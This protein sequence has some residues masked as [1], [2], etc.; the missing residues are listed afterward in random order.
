MGKRLSASGGRGLLIALGTALV[1][2]AALAL[3]T[4]Q[5]GSADHFVLVHVAHAVVYV[6]AVFFVLSQSWR[7][8]SP[9]PGG[10][11]AGMGVKEASDRE[12]QDGETAPAQ[13][14]VDPSGTSSSARHPQLLPSRGRGVRAVLSSTVVITL[15]VAVL[16]RLIAL[17]APPTLTTDAYRYVWDGR[18]Q[19]AGIN[20][21]LHVPAAP[22]LAQLRDQI[23][24]PNIN[25]ADTHPTI[26]PPVAEMLFLVGTR[27]VDGIR[28]MQVLFMAMDLM[29]IW[30]LMRWLTACGLPRE[31]VL[32]YAWHPL[33]LWEFAGMAHIDGAGVM[34][35]VL[36]LL[37]GQTGRQG[38]A[39]AA[40]AAAGLAKYHFVLLVPAVWRRWGWR[41]PLAM[42][43]VALACY[44]PYLSAGS[45]VLGSLFVHLGE[46]GYRDGYGFYLVGLPKHFGLPHLPSLVFAGLAALIL[47][48]LA[49]V[50]IQR[51]RPRTVEPEHLIWLT[52]T[53]L[54]LISPHYPWYYTLAVPLLARR[55]SWPLLWMT[56]VVSGVYLER[57]DGWL[58]P[59]TR[60]KVFTLMFGGAA[61]LAVVGWIAGARRKTAQPIVH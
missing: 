57:P 24:F 43:A 37:A 1:G 39:G 45:K 13:T 4:L 28:G 61:L 40:F 50:I 44:L 33:P 7:S 55:M 51:T 10:E 34:F 6:A 9:P 21:Y 56:L 27:V 58:E 29:T 31:R 41:L 36:G 5:R 19:A 15:A 20:P 46:E 3:W 30:A 18:V 11:G 25:R 8:T 53:F 23:I 52:I 54:V 2:L 16:M 49:V 14:I 59:A 38:W 26:Y 17:A 32:I 35:I 47:A 12:D 48:G 22:E 60:I 42:A